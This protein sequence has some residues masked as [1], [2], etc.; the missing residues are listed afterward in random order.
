[1]TG[2]PIDDLDGF[3]K[4]TGRAFRV[5]PGDADSGVIIHVPDSSRYVP[6]AVADDL[7]LDGAALERELNAMTD[8]YTDVIAERTA[9]L[10]RFRPWS[11]VNEVSRLVVD[12][13]R[14]P[15]EFEE[16]N[17]VGMGV[18]YT[19]TSTNEPLRDDDF[20][21]ADSLVE[22]CFQ[23]YAAGLANLVKA[24]LRSV[25]RVT[26]ID[27]HSYP[28]EP[29]PYELHGDGR[30]PEICLGTDTFHTSR[31][32]LETAR[33]AFRSFDTDIDSPFSGCYVPLVHYRKDERVSALMIEV[34]RDLYMDD[35]VN[36]VDL[37]VVPIADSLAA[38]IAGIDS[39]PGARS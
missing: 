39:I 3:P 33:E 2:S 18:V 35:D 11:F 37:A 38:L 7:L 16:M 17:A 22:E 9:A 19:R 1:M 10:S 23:P 6:D 20:A 27:L 36:L 34:R 13:E 8:A 12:P 4:E 28:L 32:L 25:G 14:F 5:V 29:L 21:N 24:R 15:D 30:R 26:I 31:E